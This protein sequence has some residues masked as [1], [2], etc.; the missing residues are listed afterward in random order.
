MI[1]TREARADD[2]Q[3]LS[4][5]ITPILISWNS[6]RRG[7]AEH[8]RAYY[9]EHPD[10]IRCTVAKDKSGRIVGFQ[11]LILPGGKHPL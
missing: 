8:M 10:N 2:A 1:T 11:S 7:D 9:I 4:D 6:N 3:A 5:L